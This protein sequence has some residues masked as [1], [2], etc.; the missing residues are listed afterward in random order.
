MFRPPL[1]SARFELFAISGTSFYSSMPGE[2]RMAFYARTDVEIV[3]PWP[4]HDSIFR[5]SGPTMET[6]N[7]QST[8][9]DFIG[10]A[11]PASLIIANIIG[12]CASRA[13]RRAEPSR[14]ASR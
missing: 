8:K 12:V 1:R 3:F 14:L 13:A 6:D 9:D 7:R 4:R 2:K 11:S 10:I 5:A